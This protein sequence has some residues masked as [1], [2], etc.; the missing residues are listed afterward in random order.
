MERGEL[1]IP[2]DSSSSSSSSA[3]ASFYFAPPPPASGSTS[4]G[5]EFGQITLQLSC[6]V[7]QWQKMGAG[8]QE[9]TAP[10]KTLLILV[11]DRSGSMYGTFERQVVP[12]MIEIV[13]QVRACELVLVSKRPARLQPCVA[14]H[15]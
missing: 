1:T 14:H 7:A 11:V 12:A 3:L 13:G 4:S 6:D 5:E 15:C 8:T 9:E 10:R 2:S